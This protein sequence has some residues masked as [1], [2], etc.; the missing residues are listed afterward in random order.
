MIQI[1]KYYILIREAFTTEFTSK[2]S[3]PESMSK[4]HVMEDT[5]P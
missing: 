5:Y 2:D 4:E 3:G 1:T